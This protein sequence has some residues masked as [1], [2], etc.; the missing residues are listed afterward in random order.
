[1]RT[2]VLPFVWIFN[3]QLLL[4]DIHGVFEL[5]IVVLACLVASLVFA[6]ATMGWFQTRCRWWEIGALLVAAFVLFRPNF[7]MDRVYDPYE[8]RPGKDVLA[9][10]RETPPNYPLVMIIE[11]TNVEGDD[12]RK[13]VAVQLGKEGEGPQR[14]IEA[15]LMLSALGDEVRIANV[16]FGGRARKSGFEQGWKVVGVKVPANR[17]S[18]H[19]MY[20]P[21]LAL[22][23]L[24]FFAQRRRLHHDPALA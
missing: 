20:I 14:L 1:M 10:A 13:T 11:G 3:P 18:P 9:L 2:A 7:F 6:A 19:W 12:L 24:V 21:A 4:I 23:M 17:P 22:V 15:G 5:V 16:K 8:L